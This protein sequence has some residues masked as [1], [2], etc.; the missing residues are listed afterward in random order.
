[1]ALAN[2]GNT[3]KSSSSASAAAGSAGTRLG[4]YVLLL[5]LLSACFG[6]LFL[7]KGFLKIKDYL[8]TRA[9]SRFLPLESFFPNNSDIADYIQSH[10]NRSFLYRQ[11]LWYIIDMLPIY[12]VRPNPDTSMA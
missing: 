4:N 11:V 2:S 7:V 12:V 10:R 9:E 1:M 8:P 3:A 6:S 5:F